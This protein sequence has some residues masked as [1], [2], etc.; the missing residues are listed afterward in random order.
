MDKIIQNN[1]NTILKE[2]QQESQVNPETNDN[3]N[4]TAEAIDHST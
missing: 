4:T 1:D 3:D 2:Q